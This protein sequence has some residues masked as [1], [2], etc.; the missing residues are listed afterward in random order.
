MIDRS[1]ALAAA[2][3][4]LVAAC[5]EAEPDHTDDVDSAALTGPMPTWPVLGTQQVL[6]LL[7]HVTDA[8]LPHASHAYIQTGTDSQLGAFGAFMAAGSYGRMTMQ[9]DRRAVIDVPSS[10]CTG[11]TTTTEHAILAALVAASDAAINYASVRQIIVYA[12]G[13]VPCSLGT[14]G[15]TRRVWPIA[16]GE[17][18]LDAA[19]AHVAGAFG[20]ASFG[21]VAHEYAHTIHGGHLEPKICAVN[22]FRVPIDHSSASA[23]HCVLSLPYV[24]SHEPLGSQAA[25]EF[26]LPRKMFWGWVTAGEIITPTVTNTYVIRSTESTG[27][28]VRAIR[29]PVPHSATYG[30][31]VLEYRDGTGA[32]S[33]Q[34]AGL[35]LYADHPWT[36]STDPE[37]IEPPPFAANDAFTAKPLSVGQSYVDPT[38]GMGFTLVSTVGTGAVV[39]VDFNET[40]APGAKRACCYSPGYPCDGALTCTS[41]GRWGSTCFKKCF[42]TLCL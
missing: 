20:S 14:T 35:Y 29:L 1:K 40:C 25:R 26:A 32:D 24:L 38:Y 31:Y 3:V 22:G 2:A 41:S 18:P 30:A 23:Q 8:P 5:T 15:F 13:D 39:R 34:A 4:L 11:D 33:G 12:A 7:A 42:S 10:V 9:F 37:L 16:T 19:V 21:L 28:A 17:G 27:A 6:V 36:T